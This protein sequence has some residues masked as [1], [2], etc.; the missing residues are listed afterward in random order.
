[1]HM[2][3]SDPS[4]PIRVLLSFHLEMSLMTQAA[5]KGKEQKVRGKGLKNEAQQGRLTFINLASEKVRV[6][7][8]HSVVLCVPF[9][10]V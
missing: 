3:A 8:S 4:H 7:T 6:G 1:M 10:C 9:A 2:S 5:Q